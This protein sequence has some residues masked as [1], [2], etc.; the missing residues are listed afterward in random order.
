[1]TKKITRRNFIKMLGVAGAGIAANAAGIMPLP[2]DMS[3]EG[4]IGG[5]VEPETGQKEWV[6]PCKDKETPDVECVCCNYYFCPLE[7]GSV[8]R[9]R[10]NEFC[11]VLHGEDLRIQ[12]PDPAHPGQY[13]TIATVEG[14]I[15]ETDW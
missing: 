2:V 10:R 9:W 1:M 14:L 7:A 11:E 6:H 8:Y 15:N 12:I 5:V 13:V 3:R 4:K